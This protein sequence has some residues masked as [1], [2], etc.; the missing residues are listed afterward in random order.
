MTTTTQLEES[1]ST[2]PWTSQKMHKIIAKAQTQD[3]HRA[4][5]NYD[6]ICRKISCSEWLS[7]V[8]IK[9]NYGC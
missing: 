8:Q 6:H 4:M 1:V 7:H 2:M 3:D 9:G 5:T